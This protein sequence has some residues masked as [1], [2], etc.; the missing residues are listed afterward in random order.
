MACLSTTNRT[1]NQYGQE[2]GTMFRIPKGNQARDAFSSIVILAICAAGISKTVQYPDRAAEWPL[3]MWSL[4]AFLSCVLLFNS[5]RAP[6]GA[7]KVDAGSG[8]SDGPGLS[9]SRGLRIAVN[10]ALVI[11]FVAAVPTL[12]FF[13]AG[14]IYLCVHMYYLGIRPVGRVLV[15]AVG[16]LIFLYGMFEFFLGV[17]VPHGLL[18]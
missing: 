14:M 16:T 11:G 10:I 4:L 1:D 3:W 5:L 15:V 8:S 13:T 17:L 12:G 18:F 6:I 2:E 9:K 7:T